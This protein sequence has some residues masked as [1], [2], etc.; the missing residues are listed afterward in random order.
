MADPEDIPGPPP[1]PRALPNPSG[2]RVY[3]VEQGGAFAKPHRVVHQVKQQVLPAGHE[4]RAP[5]VPG[6]SEHLPEQTAEEQIETVR[7][8]IASRV[9][10]LEEMLDNTEMAEP[11]RSTILQEI[12]RLRELEP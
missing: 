4:P 8:D 3:D 9:Q 6:V 2:L 10:V 7:Q 1:D 5:F 11:T 12:S